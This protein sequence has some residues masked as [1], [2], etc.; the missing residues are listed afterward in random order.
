MILVVVVVVVVVV[1]CVCV[2]VCAC[3]RARVCVCVCACVRACARVC[4]CVGFHQQLSTSLVRRDTAEA[5]APHL[6]RWHCING[7]S[8][9]A[10]CLCCEDFTYA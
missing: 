6:A 7:P 2:C 8:D 3:T 9:R 1:V 4:V 10:R 5:L